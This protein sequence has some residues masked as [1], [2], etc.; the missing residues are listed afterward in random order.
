MHFKVYGEF[1]VS[2]DYMPK[3]ARRIV[4]SASRMTMFCSAFT[5]GESLAFTADSE[6]IET[7]ATA[8]KDFPTVRIV[9]ERAPECGRKYV[10]LGRGRSGQQRGRNVRRYRREQP[11]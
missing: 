7:V 3:H 1:A 6:L 4:E 2:N 10:L 8:T 5:R 9:I 11:V